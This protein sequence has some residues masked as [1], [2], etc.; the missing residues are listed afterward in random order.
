MYP[1]AYIQEHS[2]QLNTELRL[3]PSGIQ[4]L[5]FSTGPCFYDASS[6]PRRAAVKG[7]V[8][9]SSALSEAQESHVERRNFVSGLKK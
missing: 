5:L 1:A 9:R 2:K 7:G 3:E 4:S 6:P 8:L